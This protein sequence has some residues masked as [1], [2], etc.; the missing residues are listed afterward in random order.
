[1]QKIFLFS[2]TKTEAR[3]MRTCRRRMI[4]LKIQTKWERYFIYFDHLHVASMGFIRIIR[5]LYLFWVIQSYKIDCTK[6]KCYDKQAAKVISV[7]MKYQTLF[8]A[9]LRQRQSKQFLLFLC[10]TFISFQILPKCFSV[11]GKCNNCV[12]CRCIVAHEIMIKYY[13][14]ASYS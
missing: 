11:I 5:S 14:I 13:A 2:D 6:R 4:F 1:M 9:Y 10:K 3:Q 7:G 12:D 8:G